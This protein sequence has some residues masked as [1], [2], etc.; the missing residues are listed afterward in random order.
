ME[1]FPCGENTET[2]FKR[3]HVTILNLVSLPNLSRA[4]DLD[5]RRLTSSIITPRE[6]IRD[7]NNKIVEPGD[8]VGRIAGKIESRER[9]GG[10]LQY[11]YR[12]AA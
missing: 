12:R 7:W 3:G 1:S 5:R 8:E 4:L 9:L 2:T 11:Y 10:M 6:I